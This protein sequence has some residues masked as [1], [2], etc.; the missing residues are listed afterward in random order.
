MGRVL[1]IPACLA[2]VAL[3]AGCGSDRDPQAAA[4]PEPVAT[5]PVRLAATDGRTGAAT[6]QSAGGEVERLAP[7]R[8]TAPSTA[9]PTPRQ[10]DGVGAGATCADVD[11][12]PTP[13]TLPQVEQATLCLLNGERAD[14]GLGPVAADGQLAQA[15]LA[16]ASEMV[17][18]SYFSHEGANGSTLTDRIRLTGYLPDAGD[19]IVGENLAWG[20][21]SLATAR[22]IVNAW[23][24]SEGH[25]ANVL[26][27][28]YEDIGLGIALGTPSRK[29]AGATYATEYGAR[30]S[31]PTTSA[32]STPAGDEESGVAGVTRSSFPTRRAIARK[33]RACKRRS[34][35]RARVACKA[36]VARLA[37]AARAAR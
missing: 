35:R 11:V 24:N 9:R 22:S 12:I 6:T 37:R 34:S 25:R 23:M 7:G 30:E 21:G 36:R 26:N 20:T 27:G 3:F 18:Q 10:R 28:R 19:W 13:E 17:E 29:D 1:C 2:A 5:A 14:R 8:R 16:H 31:V 15:A 33:R 4:A 32:P